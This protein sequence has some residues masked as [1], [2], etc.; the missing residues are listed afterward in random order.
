MD[1]HAALRR[2][3]LGRKLVP[4][5]RWR[6]RRLDV[7]YPPAATSAAANRRPSSS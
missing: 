7:T 6:A 2:M 5:L 4:L 1:P 3:T